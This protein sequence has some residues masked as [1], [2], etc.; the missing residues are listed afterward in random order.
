MDRIVLTVNKGEGNAFSSVAEALGAAEGYWGL[1]VEIR[2]SPGIYHERLHITQPRITLCGEDG[3][4]SIITF[5]HGAYEILPDGIKR[6]TFRTAT[7]FVEGRDFSARNITFK[8]AAGPGDQAGQALA[9]FVDT[10]KSRYEKC[11]FIGHQ[12]T[13]FLAPLPPTEKEK[14]GFTGPT[15]YR[16][17]RMGAHYFMDCFISGDIDFIFGGAAALFE[18]CEIFSRNRDREVNGYVAAPCTPEGEA[19]G[20]VFYHC[21]FTSDCPPRSVFLG[22]PWREYGKIDLIECELGEHIRKEG[23]DDWGKESAHGLFRFSEGGCHGPGADIGGRAS[24]VISL[25]EKDYLEQMRIIRQL[26]IE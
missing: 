9:L 18:E 24:F 25:S 17:R 11:R 21:R 16:Q 7:V 23:F 1:P 8:N 14:G 22:R 26:T 6:G 20:F 13:V 2:L 10:E 12:D 15:E 19:A 5:D 4:E 3:G